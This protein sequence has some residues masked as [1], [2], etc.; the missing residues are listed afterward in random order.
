MIYFL[1]VSTYIKS[2]M[3]EIIKIYGDKIS[4]TVFSRTII[5]K[6]Y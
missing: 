1:N 6:L 4:Y 3:H 5:W 2:L